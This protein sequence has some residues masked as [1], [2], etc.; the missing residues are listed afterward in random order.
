MNQLVQAAK[1]QNTRLAR[2]L[3]RA[4]LVVNVVLLVLMCANA[5]HGG[6]LPLVLLAVLIDF[7]VGS[8]AAS[9]GLVFELL[10]EHTWKK[11]C[12]GLGGNF[13]GQGRMQFK[14]RV[15]LD[16]IRS[17]TKGKWERTTIYPRIR[18][19]RGD[20]DSWTGIIRPLHGQCVDD[21]TLKTD[22]FALSFHVPTVSFELAERGSIR[23][24]AGKVL[25][26]PEYEYQSI[27]QAA[28]NPQLTQHQLT[29]STIPTGAL[30]AAQQLSQQ[31]GYA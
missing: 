10:V 9:Q 27:A 12:G 26:P 1:Q 7:G 19:I 5:S 20:W 15:A 17:F 18:D 11:V 4:A 2:A 22:H 6:V 29:V 3:V 8:Y 13:I 30:Q 21:Y 14:T 25:V 23:I 16:P 31:L 24:R 28:Y